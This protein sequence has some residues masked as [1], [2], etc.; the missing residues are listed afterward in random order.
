MQ[1]IKQILSKSNICTIKHLLIQSSGLQASWRVYGPLHWPPLASSNVFVLVFVLLQPLF[2]LEQSPISQFPHS[3]SIG[4]SAKF[5]IVYELVG[6]SHLKY[7]LLN[8]TKIDYSCIELSL[9]VHSGK[10]HDIVCCLSS[11]EHLST[12]PSVHDLT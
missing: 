1:L 7:Y 3:Q 8:C 12:V 5:K 6:L 10:S 4:T 2:D 11:W 9:P